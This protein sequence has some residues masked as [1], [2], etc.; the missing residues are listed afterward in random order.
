MVFINHPKQLAVS[1]YRFFSFSLARSPFRTNSMGLDHDRVLNI[2][3]FIMWQ[4]LTPKWIKDAFNL[5]GFKA[6][7]PFYIEC[8]RYTKI[9]RSKFSRAQYDLMLK[10]FASFSVCCRL[11]PTKNI[12]LGFIKK[13][14]IAIIWMQLNADAQFLKCMK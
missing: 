6:N 11:N 7:Q 9:P 5:K 8:V 10:Y 2:R 4:R 13:K 14:L 3:R 1:L 12:T